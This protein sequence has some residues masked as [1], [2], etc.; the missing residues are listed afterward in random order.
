MELVGPSKY[1]KPW[2][3]SV[4]RYPYHWSPTWFHCQVLKFRTIYNMCHVTFNLYFPL[5]TYYLCN[6]FSS[7]LVSPFYLCRL[8]FLRSGHNSNVRELRLTRNER[9]VF[10]PAKFKIVIMWISFFLN[11]PGPTIKIPHST[12]QLLLSLLFTKLYNFY[13]IDKIHFIMNQF[14]SFNKI[15]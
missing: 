10:L 3:N 15:C 5:K 14:N 11:P 9:E 12:L 2:I 7:P 4:K 1:P 13:K 8:I 6:L